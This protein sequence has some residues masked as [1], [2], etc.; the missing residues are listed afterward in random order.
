ME[1]MTFVVVVVVI[2]V[3]VDSDIQMYT[4]RENIHGNEWF[5]TIEV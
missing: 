3:V 5:I 1:T 4:L 2:S